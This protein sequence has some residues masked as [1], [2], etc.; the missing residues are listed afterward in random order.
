MA[1]PE[2]TGRK[3][4]TTPDRPKR[5][6]GPPSADQKAI[7]PTLHSRPEENTST[8]RPPIRGPP[9]AFSILE[10]CELHRISKELFFKAQ[11]EGW[12]P[13][14]MRCGTRVLISF[15]AAEA[16]R[17]EREAAAAA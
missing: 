4:I 13:K 8:K 12:G 9:L 5:G 17:R 2:I 3:L 16:W 6:S 1:R 14:V 7:E 10:F 11:R 15:E